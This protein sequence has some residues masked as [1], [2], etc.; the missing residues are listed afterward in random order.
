MAEFTGLL[1]KRRKVSNLEESLAMA[2]WISNLP[3]CLLCHIL[4]LLPFKLAVATGI[5]SKRWSLLWTLVPNLDFDDNYEQKID[6]DDEL[7]YMRN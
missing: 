7:D 1:E 2:D 3:D 5:L 6:K 4:S